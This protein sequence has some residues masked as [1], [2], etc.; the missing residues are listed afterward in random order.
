MY[1]IFAI[2]LILKKLLQLQLICKVYKGQKKLDQMGGTHPTRS[3]K[4][5]PTRPE[6]VTG[7]IRAEIFDPKLNFF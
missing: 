7:R 6:Q 1:I 2:Y 3:K 5:K 4:P